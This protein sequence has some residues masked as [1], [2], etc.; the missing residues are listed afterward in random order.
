MH[1]ALLK[2]HLFEQRR[3]SPGAAVALPLF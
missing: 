3:T 2:M 1:F